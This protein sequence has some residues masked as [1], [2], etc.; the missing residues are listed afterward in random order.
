MEGSK[1]KPEAEFAP[2]T[3]LNVLQSVGTHLVFSYRM[4][5]DAANSSTGLAPTKE[6]N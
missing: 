4:L 1:A 3:A 6:A 5:L 2:Q